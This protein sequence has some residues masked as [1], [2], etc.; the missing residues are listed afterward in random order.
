MENWSLQ[1]PP[2][3]KIDCAWLC[4]YDLNIL[5]LVRA[6]LVAVMGTHGMISG[7]ALADEQ[8]VAHVTGQ[9]HHITRQSPAVVPSAGQMLINWNNP[10]GGHPH[11]GGCTTGPL[12]RG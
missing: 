3:I 11:G 12:R 2:T 5:V 4:A 8:R 7:I 6:A 10:T 1:F 9:C